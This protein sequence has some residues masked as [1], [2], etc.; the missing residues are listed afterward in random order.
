MVLGAT[1]IITVFYPES[2]LSRP[3]IQYMALKPED[4]SNLIGQVSGSLAS[5]FTAPSMFALRIVVIVS[6]FLSGLFDCISCS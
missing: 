4:T 2:N 3:D 1:P 5:G 6:A